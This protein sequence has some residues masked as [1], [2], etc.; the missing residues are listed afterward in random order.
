[1]FHQLGVVRE[2]DASALAQPRQVLGVHVLPHLDEAAALEGDQGVVRVPVAP[3][4]HQRTSSLT[5][6]E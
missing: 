3:G 6:W 1:M 5:S 2:G 4:T